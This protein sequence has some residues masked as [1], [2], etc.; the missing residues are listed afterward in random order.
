MLM[1]REYANERALFR[2]SDVF[3][4]K[5]SGMYDDAFKIESKIEKKRYANMKSGSLVTLLLIFIILLL[6]IPNLKKQDNYHRYIYRIS[7]CVLKSCS[8]YVMEIVCGNDGTFK[9]ERVSQGLEPV[10]CIK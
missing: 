2:Y 10:L 3:S 5:Y 8:K 7:Q 6:L 1:N 9:T 4:E